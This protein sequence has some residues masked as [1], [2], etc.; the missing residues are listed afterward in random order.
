MINQ[1]KDLLQIDSDSDE[2]EHYFL[3][4]KKKEKLINELNR[5]NDSVEVIGFS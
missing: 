2:L 4:Q 5:N 3:V 1:I